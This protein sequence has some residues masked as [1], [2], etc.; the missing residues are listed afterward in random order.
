[1]NSKQLL[2]TSS[3]ILMNTGQFASLVPANS[4][5]S[6]PLRFFIQDTEFYMNYAKSDALV[7]LTTNSIMEV[8]H[9]TFLENY[10]IGRGSIVFADYQ[11]VYALFDNCTIEKNYAY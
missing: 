4:D 6:N 2:I 8:R 11:E 3:K 5:P 9:S 10:S 1:M 7:Q